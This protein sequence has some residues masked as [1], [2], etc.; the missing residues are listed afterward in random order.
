LAWKSIPISMSGPRPSR[1]D[2][3]TRVHDEN[4]NFAARSR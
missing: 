3:R 4:E 1:R 2:P